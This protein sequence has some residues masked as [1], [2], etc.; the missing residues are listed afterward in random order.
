M[1]CIAERG[2]L[3]TYQKIC[4]LKFKMKIPT[5][6]LL[7]KYPEDRNRVREV[8]LLEVPAE[9][10]REIV[11]EEKAFEKLMRLKRRF[12]YFLEA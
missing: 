7:R 3:M 6:E 2:F 9:M 8:A 12:G 5:Q 1:I 10:L 11:R 4:Y